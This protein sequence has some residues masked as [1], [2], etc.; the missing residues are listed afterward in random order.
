MQIKRTSTAVWVG[1]GKEGFGSLTSQT[2]ALKETQYGFNSRFVDGVGT[3]PEELIAALCFH[4]PGPFYLGERFI[5]GVFG[6]DQ[7]VG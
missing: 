6:S 2:T 1:T 4:F 3:N 5:R 7:I